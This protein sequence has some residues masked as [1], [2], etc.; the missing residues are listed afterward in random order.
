MAI[1]LRTCIFLKQY[2]WK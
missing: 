2:M 1:W